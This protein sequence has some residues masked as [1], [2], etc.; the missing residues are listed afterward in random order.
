MLNLQVWFGVRCFSEF[1]LAEWK[2]IISNSK[3]WQALLC[4]SL[5]RALN[6]AEGKRPFPSLPN[7]TCKRVFFS[8]VGFVCPTRVFIHQMM[9]CATVLCQS[10]L[11]SAIPHSTSKQLQAIFWALPVI[12]LP[13]E[14][15]RTLIPQL[16]MYQQAAAYKALMSTCRVIAVP[17]LL[18]AL[19]LDPLFVVQLRFPI[20]VLSTF[21]DSFLGKV[22][23]IFNCMYK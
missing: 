5:E 15:H 1:F 4:C 12:K 20:K 9:A 10:C 8:F 14:I 6:F 23:F 13:G 17:Y 7:Q 16:S 22:R 21:R 11:C 3:Q 18:C 2:N 19:L